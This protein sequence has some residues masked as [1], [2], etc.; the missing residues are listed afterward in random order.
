MY[1]M[2]VVDLADWWRF[3]EGEGFGFCLSSFSFSF[4]QLL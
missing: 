2:A 1:L 3:I 4:L